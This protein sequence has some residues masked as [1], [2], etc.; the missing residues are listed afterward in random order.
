MGTKA[1]EAWRASIA[2]DK[3]IVVATNVKAIDPVV[4][5]VVRQLWKKIGVKKLGS[6][7]DL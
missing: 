5:R 4:D 3:S 1:I 7:L 2:G 6:G